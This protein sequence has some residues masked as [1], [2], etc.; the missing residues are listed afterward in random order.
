MLAR[1]LLL[2]STFICSQ[3]VA[4]RTRRCRRRGSYQALT[5]SAATVHRSNRSHRRHG[6]QRLGRRHHRARLE[7]RRRRPDLGRADE[8]RR[9]NDH[10]RLDP[11]QPARR[12]RRT[13]QSVLGA[14]G[15]L[16]PRCGQRLDAVITDDP[17]PIQGLVVR[18][19][20][21]DIQQPANSRGDPSLMS[22]GLRR[23]RPCAPARS[24]Y[25]V[26]H[27]IATR[28]RPG[29]RRLIASRCT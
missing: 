21:S 3:L 2:S 19:S 24:R 8:R 14:S 20:H 11:D 25:T 16:R 5:V 10:P 26:L 15:A 29:A 12:R 13:Q 1:L 28:L 27:T 7:R 6:G 9:S 4:R 18:A 23:W 17:Y 22:G